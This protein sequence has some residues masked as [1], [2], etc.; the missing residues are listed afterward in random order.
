MLDDNYAAPFS[1]LGK[2]KK[3]DKINCLKKDKSKRIKVE[4][5]IRCIALIMHYNKL[6]FAKNTDNS[7]NYVAKEYIDKEYNKNKDK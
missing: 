7:T 4:K 6:T 3:G 1:A 5:G 2:R